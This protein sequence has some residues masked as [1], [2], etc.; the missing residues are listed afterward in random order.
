MLKFGGIGILRRGR[1]VRHS[2]ATERRRRGGGNRGM[3]GGGVHLRALDTS[4]MSDREGKGERKTI[5][6]DR[7]TQG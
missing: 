3:G 1:N 4:E 2:S 6:F 5:R 7:T